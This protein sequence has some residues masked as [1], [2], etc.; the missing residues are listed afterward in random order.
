MRHIAAVGCQ[1]L[2]TVAAADVLCGLFYRLVAVVDD[3]K[4]QTFIFLDEFFLRMTV[5]FCGMNYDGF[6]EKS[7]IFS[8]TYTGGGLCC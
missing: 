1:V 7:F 2:S 8:P 4:T 3:C 6:V 5:I